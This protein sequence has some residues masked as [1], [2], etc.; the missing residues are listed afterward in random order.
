MN[1]VDSHHGL[2]IIQCLYY[3]F[4][5]RS[6]NIFIL[7]FWLKCFIINEFNVHPR[8]KMS[9]ANIQEAP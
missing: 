4:P 2:S 3:A 5:L 6:F 9:I 1:K 8:K 7:V